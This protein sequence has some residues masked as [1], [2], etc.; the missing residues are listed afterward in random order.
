MNWFEVT[1]N[2]KLINRLSANTKNILRNY[3]LKLVDY[4]IAND[5]TLSRERYG[6]KT[7]VSP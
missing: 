5:K 1:G 7:I 3:V 2:I 4:K 6:G